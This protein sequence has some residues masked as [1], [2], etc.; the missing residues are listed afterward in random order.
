M[1]LESWGNLCYNIIGSSFS[2]FLRSRP[3]PEAD[4]CWQQR[5]RNGPSRRSYKDYNLATHQTRP[6]S[7]SG[8]IPG[9]RFPLAVSQELGIISRL[10]TQAHYKGQSSPPTPTH[11]E[12]FT[13]PTHQPA[14]LSEPAPGS[15]ITCACG[16][17]ADKAVCTYLSLPGPPRPSFRAGE[18]GREIRILSRAIASKLEMR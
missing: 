11:L 3:H 10:C 18:L 7:L 17:G 5:P 15:A 9:E 6:S 14:R 13:F 8:G 4:P 1:G 12:H 2:S 16:L